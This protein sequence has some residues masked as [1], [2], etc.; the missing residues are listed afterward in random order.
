MHRFKFCFLLVLTLFLIWEPT[1]AEQT[2][3]TDSFEITLRTGPSTRNQ[4][5]GMPSSGQV[6]EVL[7]SGG[8][9][10]RVRIRDEQGKGKEGWVL[11]RYLMTR[12]P[13]EMQAMALKR[14][15]VEIKDK[16]AR[17][18]A[19]L[20]EKIKT[21]REL[22]TKL[23]E[24]EEALQKLDNDYKTLREGAADYLN[25][26]AQFEKTQRTLANTQK[27]LQG[28]T[29][30]HLRLKSAQN[31]RWLAIGAIILLLGLFIGALIGRQ[32]KKR[33]SSIYSL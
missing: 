31:H 2:Y 9:W 32:E 29:E 7:E 17:I 11:S 4:V 8:D 22:S 12:I 19:E 33:R 5:I 26:S 21:E 16:L 28:L 6:V 23:K 1:R 13:W 3:V 20:N 30:A 27:E 10:S 25:L 14:E 18:E 24:T 15:N